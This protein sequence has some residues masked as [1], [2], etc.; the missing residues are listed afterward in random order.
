MIEKEDIVGEIS[1]KL[2]PSAA[3]KRDFLTAVK[4]VNFA[5]CDC[6]LRDCAVKS[7]VKIHIG[8]R[9]GELLSVS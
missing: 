9:N 6:E 1:R 8:F 7:A 2:C 4:I 3:R 5:R